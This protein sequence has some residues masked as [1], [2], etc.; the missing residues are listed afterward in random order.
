MTARLGPLPPRA[1]IRIE[2]A[3][4]RSDS[5]ARSQASPRLDRRHWRFS[6]ARL[7]WP[8]ASGPTARPDPTTRRHRTGPPSAAQLQRGSWR[9]AALPEAAVE[10]RQQLEL[11]RAPPRAPRR[12]RAFWRA[13][14][15]PLAPARADSAAPAQPIRPPTGGRAKGRARAWAH[16]RKKLPRRELG[17]R[18]ARQPPQR[19]RAGAARGPA[20]RHGSDVQHQGRAR[21]RP[22]EG[23]LWTA[24]QPRDDG[25]P[26]N[27]SW[28]HY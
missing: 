18:V 20:G 13:Q 9:C 21:G 28:G 27:H 23:G 12:E 26:V 15:P 22:S 10:T 16:G 7:T 2:G 3:H 11:P 25:R 17:A 5:I 8:L 4:R 19:T 6:P 24:R 1:V 14:A